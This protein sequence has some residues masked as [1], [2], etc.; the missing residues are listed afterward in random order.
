MVYVKIRRQN[1]TF[2]SFFIMC[3]EFLVAH[4]QNKYCP[5][6]PDHMKDWVVLVVITRTLEDS[7]LNEVFQ[8]FVMSMSPSVRMEQLGSHWTDCHEI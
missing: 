5:R 3:I 6:C 4:T 7:N 1:Y 8:L 2:S